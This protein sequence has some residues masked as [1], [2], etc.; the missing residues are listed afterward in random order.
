MVVLFAEVTEPDVFQVLTHVLGDGLATRT[1]GEVAC[2][3]ENALFE[4]LG[5]GTAHNHFFIVVGLD[6]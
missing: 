6:D 1:V 2:G 5:I 4:E 3:G